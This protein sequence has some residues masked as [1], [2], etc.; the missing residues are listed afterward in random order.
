MM[1]MVQLRRCAPCCCGGKLQ[2]MALIAPDAA[3][4]SDAERGT[5]AQLLQWVQHET[6]GRRNFELVQSVLHRFLQLHGHLLGA[7]HELRAAVV[8][9]EREVGSAWGAVSHLLQDVR[10]MYGFFAGQG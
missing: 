8:Q 7:H 6:V 3:S 4:L 2:A 5:L 9:V 10:C 1:I